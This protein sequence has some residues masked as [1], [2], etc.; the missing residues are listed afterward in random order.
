MIE[1]LANPFEFLSRLAGHVEHYLFHFPL[2]LSAVSVLRETSLLHVRR[3]VVHIHY[4]T[5]GLALAI[6]EEFG[7][8]VVDWF[9]TGA[10]FS[11]SQRGWLARL[12]GVPRLLARAVG[13]D[14]SMR[15]FGG[16]TLMVLAKRKAEP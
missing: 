1:R 11:A 6:L 8:D 14:F 16:D 13:Q 3:K 15:L 7:Y 9:Y 4:Y 2:D 12:A 5:K 10:G